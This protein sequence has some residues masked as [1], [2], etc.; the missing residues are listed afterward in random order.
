MVS[1]RDTEF[2]EEDRNGLIAS[3]CSAALCE[4]VRDGFGLGLEQ[5]R[6]FTPRRRV[7]RGTQERGCLPRRARRLC[8]NRFVMGLGW[9]WNTEGVSRRDTSFAEEHREGLFVSACSAA[10]CEPVRDGFGLSLE[11]GRGFTPRHRVRRGRQERGCLPRRAWRLCVNRFV[12]TSAWTGIGAFVRRG[13]LGWSRKDENHATQVSGNV[14]CCGC[15]Y[16]PGV[17]PRGGTAGVAVDAAALRSECGRCSWVRGSGERAGRRDDRRTHGSRFS[18]GMSCTISASGRGDPIGPGHSPI[19]QPSASTSPPNRCL[20]DA[21]VAV[22]HL[23]DAPRGIPWAC[24]APPASS[25]FGPAGAR[26]T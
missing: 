8:V 16:V 4:P 23:E 24:S 14:G 20:R 21:P 1:R 13:V 19:K 5:G 22:R 17:G 12:M 10:L 3:A 6:S 2:A 25:G 11:K 9:A 18:C 26:G 7:R 15:G